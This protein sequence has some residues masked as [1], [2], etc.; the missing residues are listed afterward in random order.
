M[1]EELKNATDIA[2]DPSS[3]SAVTYLW[4]LLLAMWGGV[5]RVV[6][7]SIFEGKTWGQIA[8]MVFFELLASGFVGIV[9]FYLCEHAG[10][11]PLYTA[12]MTAISGYMGGRSLAVLEALWK[13]RKGC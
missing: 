1:N 13:I 10:F 2:K 8:R 5:V 6:R 7:E 4:V 9:T 3:Y 11:Q 12:A